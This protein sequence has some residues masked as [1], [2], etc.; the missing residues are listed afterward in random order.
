[1]EDAAPRLEW[2]LAAAQ[3]DGRGV[4]QSAYRVL[5]A[6]SQQ[7]LDADRG[8]MWDSGRVQSGESFGVAYRGKPLAAEKTYFWKVMVWDERG[9]A[10][11]WST[12]GSWTMAPVEWKAKWIAQFGTTKDT[13]EMPLFR[14]QFRVK[15]KLVRA[16]LDVSALGQ[17]EVHLNGQ[18]VGDAEL[19]P[20]WT[21]YRKTVRYEAYDVIAMLRQGENAVGVM[22]GNGM[23]NVVKTPHRYTKLVNSFGRPMVMVQMR[24]TLRMES[25]RSSPATARGRRPQGRSHFPRPMAERTTTLRKNNPDGTPRSFMTRLGSR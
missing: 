22:V 8:D 18:K 7:T 6:S 5:V 20:S 1:M 15:H 4:G 9:D 10:A 17:G 16:M 12:T 24:L 14:K 2:R 21:D 23:F 19:A 11:P 13:A 25:P 3:A